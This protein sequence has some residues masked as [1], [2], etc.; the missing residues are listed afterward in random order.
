MERLCS[1][2]NG[3]ECLKCDSYDVV[4]RLLRRQALSAC[5][6]VKSQH[7]GLLCLGVEHLFHDLCPD[8][9]CGAKLRNF[10]KKIV[11]AGEEE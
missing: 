9:T 7:P 2:K 10:L 4:L 1:S 5:L 6:G 8:S 11:P 3:G